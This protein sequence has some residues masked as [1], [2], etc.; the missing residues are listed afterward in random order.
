MVFVGRSV[1]IILWWDVGQLVRGISRVLFG[2]E[3]P[4]VF[5]EV[6]FSTICRYVGRGRSDVYWY[7]F[8]F[9]RIICIQFK[10]QVGLVVGV[11]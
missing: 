6:F 2:G 9:S 3:G 8:G 1:Y 7:I 4:L 5:G 10:F 11:R